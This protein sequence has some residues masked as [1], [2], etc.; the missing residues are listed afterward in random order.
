[1]AVCIGNGINKR[2]YTYALNFIYSCSHEVALGCGMFVFDLGILFVCWYD[3][4]IVVSCPM[5]CDSM[6]ANKY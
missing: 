4:Y 2:N 1:M 5:L 6:D 3:M